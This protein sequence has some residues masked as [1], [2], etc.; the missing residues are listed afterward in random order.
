LSADAALVD[1]FL[2]KPFSKEA[3]LAAVTQLC[4]TGAP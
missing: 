2:A 1:L 4:P 3:I